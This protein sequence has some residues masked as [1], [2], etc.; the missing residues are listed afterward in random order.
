MII[1]K[2][3]FRSNINEKTELGINGHFLSPFGP[4]FLHLTLDD[5]IRVKLLQSVTNFRKDTSKLDSR[6]FIR[7]SDRGF[8]SQKNSIADGEM[9]IITDL[10]PFVNDIIERLIDLYFENYMDAREYTEKPKSGC[11]MA[12]FG[13]MKPGDFHMIQAHM[14]EIFSGLHLGDVSGAIY[15][16]VPEDLPYPQGVITWILSGEDQKLS[17]SMLE[18]SPESGEVYVWPS[19]VKHQVYP[20]SGKKERIM[21]SFNG[22]WQNRV[23]PNFREL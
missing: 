5:E 6:I 9:Y 4:Q 21:I 7:H 15:L 23:L 2:K 14:N 13:V 17:D 11:S 16:D 18:A 3:V 10:D 19:W 12:W 8:E 20:F 22:F 1:N